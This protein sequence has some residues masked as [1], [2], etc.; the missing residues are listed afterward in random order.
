MFSQDYKIDKTSE[1]FIENKS[2]N[3]EQNRRLDTIFSKSLKYENKKSW[4]IDPEVLKK[5]KYPTRQRIEML[6]DKDS[7]FVELSQLAG[8]ELYGEGNFYIIFLF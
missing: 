2:N 1:A 3:L 7:F 5:K 6:L 4:E 8:H